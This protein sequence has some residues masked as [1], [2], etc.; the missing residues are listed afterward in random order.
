[1]LRSDRRDV[2]KLEYSQIVTKIDAKRENG[3]QIEAKKVHTI[4]QLAKGFG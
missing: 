4:S 1:M 2:S 3:E